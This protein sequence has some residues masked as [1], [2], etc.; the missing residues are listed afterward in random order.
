MTSAQ[1]NLQGKVAVITGGGGV[2]CGEMAKALARQG[3]KIA[4]LSRRQENAQKVADEILEENGEAIAVACDVLDKD[5]IVAADEKIQAHY[6]SYDI[7]INGA[8]GNHPD[9]ATSEEYFKQDHLNDEDTKSFFDLT[10]EGMEHVFHL[11][12]IGAVLSTQV[13]MKHMLG[14]E[15]ASVI[16]ISSMSAPS[17]MTKVVSYSAAKAGIDNFTQWL[18]VHMAK[19]NVRCNAIAPGFFLT[20]QN[21]NLLLNEDGSYTERS[22]KIISHTP[23]ERF[24]KP[25]DLTGTLLWL[26]DTGMSR[27]VN[28]VTIPVDGGFMA[29]SGV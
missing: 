3:V 28:G 12:Y 9:A 4:V 2:L 16:N 7:L 22:N 6:K 8:G 24:G 11:N 27:F 13:F 20:S 21:R 15:D 19:E 29:Y 14:K 5:S 26:A 25:E 1:F 23:M 10:K 17:P 18:A